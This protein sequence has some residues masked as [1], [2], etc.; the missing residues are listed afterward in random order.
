MPNSRSCSKDIQVHCLDYVAPLWTKI[1]H[2]KRR[3]MFQLSSNQREDVFLRQVYC[4]G[5]GPQGE[6]G[7]GPN[8]EI[9]SDEKQN[10][11]SSTIRVL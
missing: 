7:S 6:G 1:M 10:F 3:E 2:L 11:L 9:N 8:H 5:A 4:L